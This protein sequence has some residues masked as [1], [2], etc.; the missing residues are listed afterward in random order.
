M[1]LDMALEVMKNQ[2]SELKQETCKLVVHQDDL[3]KDLKNIETGDELIAKLQL[4]NDSYNKTE[5]QAEITRKVRNEIINTL[6]VL[7]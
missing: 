1:A 2:A 6:E 3:K 4:W 5:K 7:Y